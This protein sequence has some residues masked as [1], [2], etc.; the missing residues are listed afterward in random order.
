MPPRRW[1]RRRRRPRSF[2]RLI[3]AGHEVTIGARTTVALA[4]MLEG[5]LDAA[6]REIDAV[7]LHVAALAPAS[8]TAG[9]CGAR[10]RHD[11]A[12]AR[13][14]PAAALQHL[15]PLGDSSQPAPKWQRERMRAWAQIGLVQLDQG[16]PAQAIVSF[17][18]ALKEFERLETRVTPAHADALVGLGRAH[19]AQGDA[20]KALP[21]LEQAD[22][23]WRGFDPSNRSAEAAEAGWP[24]PAPRPRG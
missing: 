14:D 17:E 19:L 23:F 9:A 20:A 24:A 15:Q 10:A 16:A 7:A 3:G 8:C 4:L 6:A 18:R 12:R 21:S 22:L 1:P 2:D 13:A 5:R 11:R